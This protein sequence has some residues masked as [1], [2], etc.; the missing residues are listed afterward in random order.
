LAF[1]EGLRGKS[2]GTALNEF[3]AS[4][5]SFADVVWEGAQRAWDEAGDPVSLGGCAGR[6]TAKPL[7][8]H[9]CNVVGVGQ[10]PGGCDPGQEA[11]DVVTVCFGSA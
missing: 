1:A 3:G 8:Q 5:E 9:G 6:C 11:I 10:A 2:A 4:V 7:V